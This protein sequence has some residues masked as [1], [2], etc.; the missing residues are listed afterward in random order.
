MSNYDEDRD[1]TY[2]A[3]ASRKHDSVYLEKEIDALK[4]QI[5]KMQDELDQKI[6]DLAYLEESIEKL[7][8]D[9]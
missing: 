3:I 9:L 4:E 5:E 1:T 6:I 2:R 8:A 7:E